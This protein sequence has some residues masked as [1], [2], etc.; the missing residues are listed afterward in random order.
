[1]CKSVLPL[2]ST[3][4]LCWLCRYLN[5]IGNK[6]IELFDMGAGVSEPTAEE[7]VKMASC[8]IMLHILY[9]FLNGHMFV[10]LV[11]AFDLVVIKSHEF[12]W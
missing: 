11:L 2:I 8:K 5:T 7:N 3:R 6:K 10:T 4:L 9:S 12:A 1:M